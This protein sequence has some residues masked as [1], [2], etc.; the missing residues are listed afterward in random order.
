MLYFRDIEWTLKSLSLYL[1]VELLADLGAI[2][3]FF[4][5]ENACNC[6]GEHRSVTMNLLLSH[7][8]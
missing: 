2:R 1:P 7:R 6:I 4:T 3:L 8:V 5:N